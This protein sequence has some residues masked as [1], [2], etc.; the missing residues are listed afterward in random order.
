M[1]LLML[2]GCSD[3]HPGDAATVGSTSISRDQVDTLT[4]IQCDLAKNTSPSQSQGSSKSQPRAALVQGTV[5]VLV[6]TAVDNMYGRS[7]GASFDNNVLHS[8]VDQFKAG[9]ASLP[10]DDQDT[11]VQAFTDYT[12]GQLLLASI[13][14]KKLKEQGK[15]NPGTT[16]AI[17]VGGNLAGRWA[18]RLH[19]K[20][21]PR[22]NPGTSDQAGGGDGSISRVVSSYAKSAAGTATPT[23]VAGL[24][25]EMRCG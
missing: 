8:Q 7:V 15:Q 18:K 16:E 12:R 6:R 22:Y 11:L 17:T 2:T 25:A 14:E 13:G 1:A 10:Q 19:I 4:R 20:I 9:V 3:L 23:F 24:P 5:N 21:D